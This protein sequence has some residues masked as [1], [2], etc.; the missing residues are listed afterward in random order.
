MFCTPVLPRDVK[1]EEMV[2]CEGEKRKK[3]GKRKNGVSQL[4]GTHGTAN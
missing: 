1:A 3:V 2:V 4:Q